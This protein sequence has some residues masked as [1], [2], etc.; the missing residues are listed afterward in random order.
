MTAVKLVSTGLVYRNPQPFLKSIHAWHP[1]LVPLDDG[2]LLAAFDLAE[3]VCARNYRS[4]FS[5]S[6][7]CGETWTEPVRL[8]PNHT[9]VIDFIR[10]SRLSN[11]T[12]IGVGQRKA[13]DEKAQMWNP[14]TYG[15]RE[16]EWFTIRSSDCGETWS[17]P[18]AFEPAITGQPYE[19]CHAIVE[20]SD[21]RLLLP[22]GLARTWE[23]DTPNGLKTI[24]M[25]SH[26]QGRTWP[27][28]TELFN[29]PDGNVIFHEVSLIEQPNGQLV[30]VAWPFNPSE[31]QTRLKV[32]FA[33]A[34]DG[35]NFT[36]RGS[37][38]IAG[39]TTKIVSLGD[40]RVLALSRRTDETGLWAIVARIDGDSWTNLA[41][42]PVW[43][44]SAS[45]MTGEKA[46]ADDLAALHFGF[47]NLHLLP[48]GDVFAAFWCREDCIHNIR[49]L[50]IR[51]D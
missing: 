40:D 17:D 23:G 8:V 2:Q 13:F 49:W 18:V 12:I 6:R 25:V 43:Q 15:V 28:Y 50:R 47:P 34:P 14:E 35:K 3:A 42:A 33:I 24:A 4:Y 38:D 19:H 5:H 1:T 51:V 22:A 30:T 46:A 45:R 31:G 7:D 27:E 29:D 16:G 21:G 32:P 44:G 37:T 10:I 20:A 39:E 26:D 36:L 9:D 41:E 11:D 48:D